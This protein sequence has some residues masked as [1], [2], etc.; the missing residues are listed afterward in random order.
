MRRDLCY[1]YPA[2]V[3][4][5][6]DAFV[7][8]ANRKFGKNCRIDAFRTI[9][10]GLDYSF[11]YNMNGGS[12][13]LHFMPYQNGTAI[14]LRYTVVQLMG[15]RYQRH[16]DD[17]LAFVNAVL[18]LQAQPLQLD[19]NTFLAYETSAASS[20]QPTPENTLPGQPVTPPVPQ[21]QQ[22]RFC[23]NCGAPAVP[24]AAFCVNCGAKMK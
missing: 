9:S 2:P 19:I 15:A 22:R 5:V 4:P 18:G 3:Q 14:D 13:T 21:P 17:I 23:T 16:A 24:C 6:F 8:A 10:F 7:Q 1:F 11:R 20:S 12:L